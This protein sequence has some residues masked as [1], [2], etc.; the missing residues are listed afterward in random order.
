VCDEST[1]P[2]VFPAVDDA[3]VECLTVGLPPRARTHAWAD[4]CLRDATLAAAATTEDDIALWLYTSGTTGQPKAV[5]HRHRSLRS[6]GEHGLMAQVAALEPDDIVLSASKA[7]FAYG[8]G[9]SIY[10]PAARGASVLLNRGPSVPHRLQS[11]M[12]H[13]RTTV[14]CAV[15]SFLSAYVRRPEADLPSSV[16]LVF[17]AG[18]ALPADL[19]DAFASRFR[20]TPLDG[21]GSTEALHHVTSSRPDDVVV[22]SA[23]RPLDGYEIEV[24][25]RDGEPVRDGEQG[26]LWLR[27]PTVFAGYWRRPDLTTRVQRDGWIR[28]GDAVRMKDGHLFHEGRLDDLFKLGGMWVSPAGIEEVIRELPSVGEAAVVMV[29]DD[30]GVPV[31]KAFVVPT[32]GAEDVVKDVARHCRERLAMFKRPRYVQ[33]VDELP[34]TPTGKLRRFALREAD[35][36]AAGEP[37]ILR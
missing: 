1:A 2:S 5:M 14:L 18:E 35:G 16:R 30:I 10:Q 13:H 19:H 32:A 3:D 36:A 6:A 15:P 37:F 8:L 33:V 28:T 26:E 34:R 22:G 29:D 9:N 23:G 17:S 11:L 31:L 7:F 24:R 12:A 4:V 21:L 27:G 25:D 20:R